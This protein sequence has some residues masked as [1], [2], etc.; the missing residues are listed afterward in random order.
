MTDMCHYTWLCLMFWD[1]VSHWTKSSLIQQG[2]LASESQGPFCLCI[3]SSGITGMHRHIQCFVF[4]F[5]SCL[6]VLFCFS[7]IKHRYWE[8][9][10]RSLCLW[11][12]VFAGCAIFQPHP[13]PFILLLGVSSGPVP[14]S[15]WLSYLG[16]RPY[17]ASFTYCW[18]SSPRI[19]VYLLL[20]C[21]CLMCSL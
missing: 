15:P 13:T 12:E 7:C 2:T 5:L 14:S 4:V 21:F 8:S 9:Q 17:L 3:L 20:S 16:K 19:E 18:T 1:K 10:L 11:G 6:F